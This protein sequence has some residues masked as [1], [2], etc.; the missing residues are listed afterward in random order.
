MSERTAIAI[1]AGLYVVALVGLIFVGQ[2]A[3]Q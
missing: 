3:A 1:S 2:G